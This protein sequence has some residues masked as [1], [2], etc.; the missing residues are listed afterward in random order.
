MATASG[1]LR[2]LFT[3][4]HSPAHFQYRVAETMAGMGLVPG[5]K[6]AWIRPQPFTAK[7]TY[8][9]ARLGRWRLIAEIPAG[10]EDAFWNAAPDS[11]EQAL[12]AL[13]ATGAKALIATRLPAGAS[14]VGWRPAGNTGFYLY[15]FR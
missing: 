3:W 12:R 6:V 4:N 1:R 13:A 10:Q 14:Q 5:D 8:W 2:D 9:W 7:Q 15:A 11:R